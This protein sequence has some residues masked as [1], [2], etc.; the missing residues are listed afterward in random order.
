MYGRFGCV[1]DVLQVYTDNAKNGNKQDLESRT[2]RRFASD[3][4][5]IRFL[6]LVFPF[7]SFRPVL[8]RVCLCLSARCLENFVCISLS[9]T[10]THLQR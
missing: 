5:E 3:E 2:R 7:R 9:T 6:P 4:T 1:V 10:H 8:F